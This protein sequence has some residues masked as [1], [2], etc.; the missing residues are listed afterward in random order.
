G[1][2]EAV[3]VLALDAAVARDALGG[4][5]LRRGLIPRPVRCLEVAGAVDRVGPEPDV[6]HHLE[7]A[8]DAAV[9]AARLDQRAHEMVGLLARP[10][11]RVD[12]RAA[13]VPGL[14]GPEPGVAGDVVRLLAGL[15]DAAADQLLDL[16]RIDPRLLE[17]AELHLGQQLARVQ[18]RE[19]PLAHLAPCDRRPKRLDDHGFTHLPS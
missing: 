18:T 7:T 10:A 1:E 12:R 15:G 4:L 5:E 3:D 2:A 11:L 8:R 17:Q 19:V 16:L 14:A 9:D 13:R 6:A